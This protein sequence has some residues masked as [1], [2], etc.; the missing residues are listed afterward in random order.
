M[1]VQIL[2]DLAHDSKTPKAPTGE[3]HCLFHLRSSWPLPPCAPALLRPA[4]PGGW[5]LGPRWAP[6]RGGHRGNLVP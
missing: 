2:H 6:K 4:G 5:C 1:I 3:C